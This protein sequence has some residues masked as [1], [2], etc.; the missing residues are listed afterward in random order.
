MQSGKERAM[1]E[2]INKAAVARAGQLSD[3]EHVGQW[4]AD[5]EEALRD[6]DR[7]VL[8]Q[9]FV[10]DSRWRDLFAFSWNLTPSNTRE[11]IVSRL[12]REQPRMQACGFKPADGRTPPRRVKRTGVE[13]IE[14]IFQFETATGR[15]LG[16]L[17]LSA[18]QPDKA[19]AMSTSLHELKGHEEPVGRRR[20]DGSNTRI[21]GGESWAERRAREQRYDDREPAVLIVGGGRN[22]LV[23]AARLRQLGVDALVVERLARVGDVWRRRYSALALHNETELNQLPY[24]AYPTSWPK[25]LPTSNDLV[26]SGVAYDG[27]ET[28]KGPALRQTES[29]AGLPG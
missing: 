21:F 14:S 12:L 24:M 20:P 15:C 5:F 16:V 10:E 17:R 26:A 7:P 22:G 6:G 23:L 25:Y 27:T 28:G 3:A 18:A 11:V 8:E 29:L 1:Q 19:W 9:L 13:V 2:T 4:L